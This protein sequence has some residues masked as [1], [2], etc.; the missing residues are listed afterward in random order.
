MKYEQ[1][2]FLADNWKDYA[3]LDSGDGMTQEAVLRYCRRAQRQGRDVIPTKGSSVPGKPIFST[4]RA[5][6]HLHNDRASKYGLKLYSIGTDT[7]SRPHTPS[8]SPI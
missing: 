1:T 6:D 8:P 2:L 4:P 3:L 7:A 5:L